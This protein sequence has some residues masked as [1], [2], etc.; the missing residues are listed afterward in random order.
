MANEINNNNL[1]NINGGLNYDGK[2]YS[3]SSGDCFVDPY[4]KHRYIVTCDHK[5]I[6]AGM[7][8]F[9]KCLD[10]PSITEINFEMLMKFT[11]VGNNVFNDVD[12]K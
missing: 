2:F 8:I 7:L 4:K 1:K 10:F 9:V 3:L 6:E 11:Y 5:D 12:S